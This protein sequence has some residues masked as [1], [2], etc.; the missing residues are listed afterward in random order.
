MIVDSKT[1]EQII[2]RFPGLVFKDGDDK[3]T[4]EGAF[5][6]RASFNK[7]T[8]IYT[9]NPMTDDSD[10]IDTTYQIRIDIPNNGNPPTVYEIGGR[11]PYDIDFHKYK[12]GRLCLAGPFDLIDDLPLDIF[13]DTLVLEFLYDQSFREKFGIWPRGVYSHGTLGVIENYSDRLGSIPNLDE[14]CLHILSKDPDFKK[15]RDI[16][17]SK[18]QIRGHHTCI[19][20]SGKQYRKC[21]D[22]ALKGLWNLQTFVG[23]KDE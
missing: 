19:C 18:N 7:D 16:L 20:G 4:L 14:Y 1:R 21:H 17:M 23:D 10:T 22:K 12:D 9:I 8:N 15:Y 3:L 11:I 6:F 2:S 13:M 5:G